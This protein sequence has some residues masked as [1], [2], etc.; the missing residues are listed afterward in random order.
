MACTFCATGAQGFRR[1]LSA[2]E[3]LAQVLTI[4][5]IAAADAGGDAGAGLTN[6]VFMGMGRAAGELRRDARG[7][8]AADRRRRL[9]YESAPDHRLERWG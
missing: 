9:R 1:Q 5:R 3:I 2:G 7:A 6:V 4:G 8:V